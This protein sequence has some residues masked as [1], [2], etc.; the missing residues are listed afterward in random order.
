M[1]TDLL[2]ALLGLVHSFFFQDPVE[3]TTRKDVG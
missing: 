2:D 3:M 1:L